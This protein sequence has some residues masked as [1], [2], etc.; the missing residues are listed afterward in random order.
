MVQ[1]MAK[2]QFFLNKLNSLVSLCAQQE[3]LEFDA[4]GNIGD[5]IKMDDGAFYV[6][7][8]PINEIPK[9]PYVR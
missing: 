6:A 5:L 8:F 4:N 1:P 9:G 3:G 2:R 7:P